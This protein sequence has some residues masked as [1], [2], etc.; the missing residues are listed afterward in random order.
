MALLPCVA[1]CLL[2]AAVLPTAALGTEVSRD[3]DGIITIR[4]DA[5][6]DEITISVLA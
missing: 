4:G 1:V 2:I 3:G 6:V 5:G